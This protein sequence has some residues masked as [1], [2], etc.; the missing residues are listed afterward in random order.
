MVACLALGRLRG[1]H[2][3]RARASRGCLG[4]PTPGREEG[5]GEAMSRDAIK[6]VIALLA[7][8]LFLARAG[9]TA[10]RVVLVAFWIVAGVFAVWR[11]RR[12]QRAAAIRN[13]PS[14]TR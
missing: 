8:T 5:D 7:A 1:L 14:T 13:E 2:T 12:K 3:C 10:E 11:E 4:A 9:G 6:G